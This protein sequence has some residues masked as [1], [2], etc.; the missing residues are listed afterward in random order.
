MNHLKNETSPYLLQ[1]SKN[2]VDWYPWTQEAL[3][4][5]R[6]ENKLLIISIG[7]AA[8]HWCHVMEKECFEDRE[9]AAVMNRNFISIKVDRE[10]RP[11][12][13]HV[14]MS[15]SYIITGRGGWPLNVIAL[16]DGMPV[17]AGTY[18]P[19]SD[20]LTV[21]NH[22][23]LLYD[24]KEGELR[25]LATTIHGELSRIDKPFTG[26]HKKTTEQGNPDLLFE[27]WL[28]ILDFKNGGITGAPKFPMP[29]NLEFLM[30]YAFLSGNE[31][32]YTAVEI[33]LGKI[34]RGGIFDH[35]GG[36]FCRYSTDDHWHIPHFEKMLYDNAQ[37]VSLYSHAYQYFRNPLY[38]EVVYSTLKFIERDLTAP[39]GLFYSS[40]DADSEG[41]E[42]TFYVWRSEEIMAWLGE[43][44]GLFMEFF[45]V[46]PDGNWENGLNVLHHERNEKEISFKHSMSEEELKEK[47]NNSKDILLKIREQRVYPE[48]DTKILTSWNALMISAYVSTFLTFRETGYLSKAINTA[49]IFAEKYVQKDGKLFRVFD[50]NR[51]I[52]NGF[53]DDYSFLV[54]AFI[55]LYQ[56]TFNEV[57]LD[58]AELLINYAFAHFL[59][60]QT[61]LFYYTSDTDPA[62]IN[63]T[64]DLSDNVIPS[65][66][67][68]MAI[69]LFILGHLLGK[70]RWI[71]HAGKMIT[72]V[73]QELGSNPG[74]YSNWAILQTFFAN[75]PY[76]VS[77]V[78]Q[79]WK[80][81]HAELT[82]QYLPQMILSG[83]DTE[84]SLEILKG[85][86]VQQKTLIY[87]CRN[88]VCQLPVDNVKEALHLLNSPPQ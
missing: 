45:D 83:G 42:G 22:F 25:N 64:I 40:L 9:V 65:S 1:H 88:K 8:C 47:V 30:A 6:N 13:D 19:K 28:P 62:L 10:E 76:E 46:T 3:D 57:W 56:S 53:L 17:Y 2:P 37:L 18:F 26:F 36:G 33:S 80:N 60:S 70:G 77:I 35:L 16:P 71:D 72:C 27:K 29:N 34:A 61:G 44:A 39:G 7:Y 85:K 4:K 52:I 24:R 69:N 20:W 59:D 48:K 87:V 86:L 11:D 54:K 75:P 67:S 81:L 74:Y 55:A 15:A 63:R 58:T 82:A 68:Q 73:L 32:A 23:A 43:N 78:G 49:E 84:G 38:K 50:N 51:K 14:Y 31:K 66:N 5:A 41:K 12:I 79:N 21:L